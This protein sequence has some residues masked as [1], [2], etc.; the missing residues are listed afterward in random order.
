MWLDHGD[1]G[2]SQRVGVVED[3]GRR[4]LELPVPFASQPELDRV[5]IDR[6]VRL[7]LANVGE[8]GLGDFGHGTG[9]G[10]PDF[11]VLSQWRWLVLRGQ[12]CRRGGLAN[13]PLLQSRLWRRRTTGRLE[14]D[15][16][17]SDRCLAGFVGGL[18]SAVPLAAGHFAR[19]GARDSD[20][21]RLSERSTAQQAAEQVAEMLVD[22]GLGSDA[23]E[24]DRDWPA[25]HW[26][27]RR[28]AILAYD[29][30]LS[31]ELRSRRSCNLWNRGARCLAC[32]Q[33]PPQLADGSGVCLA[34][35]TSARLDRRAGR[36]AIRSQPDIT[37]LPAAM[38]QAS[39]NITR[40]KPAGSMP[41]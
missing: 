15:R 36:S 9:S 20:G 40:A 19:S 41:A 35:S 18:S 7:N 5:Y 32:Y 21:R 38:R 23:I 30:D 28:V 34:R 2:R 8:F 16:W 11:V 13:A 26:A 6:N 24:D 37:G 25:A 4:V 14:S 3:G 22:L 17:N 27:S 10:R 33:L 39:W 12:R 1:R 29:P 31:T